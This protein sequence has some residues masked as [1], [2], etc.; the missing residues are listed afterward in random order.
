MVALGER[1]LPG[2]EAPSAVFARGESADE[3]AKER[4]PQLE[5]DDLVRRFFRAFSNRDGLAT[6]AS[7]PS[8]FL[9]E[10]VVTIVKP[11]VPRGLEVVSVRDFVVPRAELLQNG[12]VTDF[13][14]EEVSSKT[15]ILGH[16]AQRSTHYRKAGN[17]DGVPFAGGGEKRFQLVLTKGGWKI[18]ALAW[19]DT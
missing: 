18:A 1:L 12:R 13:G 15:E 10:A 2:E 6:I 14:E 19:E 16:L 7:V 17:L 9:P 8:L 4:D 3:A 5:I 11:A